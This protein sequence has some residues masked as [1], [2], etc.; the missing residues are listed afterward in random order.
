[1][2]ESSGTLFVTYLNVYELKCLRVDARLVPRLAEMAG[3]VVDV[4][5]ELGIDLFSS[6]LLLLL[7]TK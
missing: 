7:L 5:I 4:L 6:P 3:M 1:M 2:N